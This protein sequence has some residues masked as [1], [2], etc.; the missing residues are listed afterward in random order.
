[1]TT[2]NMPAKWRAE[3]LPSREAAAMDGAD[4][5]NVGEAV[6]PHV[7]QLPKRVNPFPILIYYSISGFPSGPESPNSPRVTGPAVL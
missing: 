6:H 7:S 5:E 1:M 2:G 4:D 3:W